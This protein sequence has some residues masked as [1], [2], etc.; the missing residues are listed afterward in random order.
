MMHIN[1]RKWIRLPILSQKLYA[2]RLLTNSELATGTNLL[3]QKLG[4]LSFG[5]ELSFAS[6]H[7]NI[8]GLT[9]ASW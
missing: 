1:D 7:I 8:F 6:G 2:V 4:L 5:L 9:R 3:R